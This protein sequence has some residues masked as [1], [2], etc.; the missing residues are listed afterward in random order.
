[1]NKNPPSWTSFLSSLG[2][3]EMHKIGVWPFVFVLAVS[4]VT[5]LLI[6]FLYTRLYSSRT[7]GS[8]IHRAFPLLGLSVTAIFICIQF[9]LPLSLGLLGALSIVR[10]RTPIKEP[11]EIGFILLVIAASLA[12][13]TFSFF[14]LGAILVIAVAALLVKENLPPIFRRRGQSGLVILTFPEA[15][16]EEKREA[17][18]KLLARELPRGELESISRGQEE[19]VVNYRFQGLAASRIPAAEA[20]LR[21]ELAARD[22]TLVCGAPGLV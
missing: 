10:F 4:V 1:M 20:A 2:N 7:T 19:V 3:E 9:S 12:A 14:L 5:A 8:E 17:I 22:T 11:E 6:A 18:F 13:A 21:S 15:G 16:Y